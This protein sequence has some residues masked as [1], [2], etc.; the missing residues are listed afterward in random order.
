MKSTVGSIVTLL[1]ADCPNCSEEI[2]TE[3]GQWE[4]E[5]GVKILCPHCKNLC[6]V[7]TED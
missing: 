2:R 1:I 4:S 5:G 6:E 3:K 7:Y